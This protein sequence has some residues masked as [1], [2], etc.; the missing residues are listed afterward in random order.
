M[1][2]GRTTTGGR[3]SENRSRVGGTSL[4][5][6]RTRQSLFALAAAGLFPSDHSYRQEAAEEA[7]RIF[8]ELGA[9][10]M[11]AQL[12]EIEAKRS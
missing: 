5:G 9:P 12:D 8:T 3:A 11:L 2:S 7:R 1:L 6:A 10:T 4:K